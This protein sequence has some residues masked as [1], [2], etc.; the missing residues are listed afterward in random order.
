[1]FFLKK[2]LINVDMGMSGFRKENP[3]NLK[4]EKNLNIVFPKKMSIFYFC[5]IIIFFFK[6]RVLQT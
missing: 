3:L 1:M 5:L 2:H 6:E 4:K